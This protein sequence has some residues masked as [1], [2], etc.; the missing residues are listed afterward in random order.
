M[1][2]FRA[3]TGV[4]VALA[5]LAVSAASAHAQG[6]T[7]GAITGTV[8]DENGR[9][10]E[11]A[12]IQLRN[13]ATGYS[14]GASTRASGLYLIQGV[15]PNSNYQL[16]VRMIGFT[17]VTRGGVVITLG[18][19]RR[20]DFKLSRQAAQLAQVVVT[21]T[22]DPVI[23]ASKTG[24]STTISDSALHRLPTLNRNFQDFVSLVPQVST[25]TG[26]LSGGGV[27]LR[28][29]AIQIDGAQ[30]GDMFVLGTTGQPGSQANAKSIPLDAV[31]EYQALLSPFDVRQGNFGGL[32]INAAT[33]RGTN[34][35]QP[36]P[37][38]ERDGAVQADVER[39][40]LQLEDGQHRRGVPH[41][42]DER[43]VQ[44]AA[45]QPVVD[46]GLPHR[47]GDVAAALRP[48]HPA[49]RRLVGHGEL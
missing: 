20:E 35:L 13:P 19:T 45:A 33:K 15:E 42:P 31:K 39:L 44:R 37:Q 48:R 38:D 36:R 1:L 14:I 29:N 16:T 26:Y 24:T 46:E 6:V 8:T 18:Q 21:A 7:T 23:T 17:P 5:L 47:A 34:D 27:N 30:S 2:S 49:H 11:A 9:P 3:R 22:T 25:T 41:E 40:R 32:L 12:Q 4:A 43:A 28:Q 10:I